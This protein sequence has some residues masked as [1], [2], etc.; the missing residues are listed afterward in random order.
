MIKKL[1][2]IYFD[3]IRV[4]IIINLILMEFILETNKN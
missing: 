3:Q 4:N 1:A 2:K